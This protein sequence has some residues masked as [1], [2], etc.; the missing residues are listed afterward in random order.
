VRRTVAI[1]LVLMSVTLALAGC[2]DDGASPSPPGD[3]ASP[4]PSASANNGRTVTDLSVIGCATEDPRGTGELTGA[5]EDQ[6]GNAYYIRH[7]GDCVWWFGTEIEDIEPGQT[8]RS[9]FANVAVGRILGGTLLELEYADLP[10]GDTL[11][12][13]G[14]TFVY[15]RENDQLVLTAQRGEWVPFGSST[16]TRSVPDLSEEPTPSESASS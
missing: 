16:L 10:L 7:I 12:G 1:T 2:G 14:I 3:Q 11:G 13:G 6:F 8:G 15:D 4:V 5:W 9:G